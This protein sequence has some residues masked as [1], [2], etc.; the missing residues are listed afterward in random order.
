MHPTNSALVAT[1]QLVQAEMR[2]AQNATDLAEAHL[3]AETAVNILVGKYGRWYGDQNGDGKIA[4]PSDKRGI[5]PGEKSPLSGAD[6]DAPVQ[7]PFGL[8]LLAVGSN[9]NAPALRPLL[10]DVALWQTKPRAG[11]DTIANALAQKQVDALQGNLPRAV[12]FAR[13]ILTSAQTADDARVFA[14][15]AVREL[16]AALLTA[17]TIPN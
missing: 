4:D 8:V 14:A 2:A 11:Y 15:N 3:H 9:S 6:S 1:L 10:G 13:L 5:L 12:A 17:Q 7:F 16:D